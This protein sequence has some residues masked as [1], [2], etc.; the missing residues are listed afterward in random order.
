MLCRSRLA[1]SISSGEPANAS[2][3]ICAKLPAI[4]R[5]FAEPLADLMRQRAGEI[6]M[7]ENGS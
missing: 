6:G 2:R 4:R 3:A 1:A 7:I 5:T